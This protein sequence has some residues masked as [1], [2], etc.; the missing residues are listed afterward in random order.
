MERIFHLN[1]HFLTVSG[2]CVFTLHTLAVNKKLGIFILY[3]LPAFELV[4]CDLFTSNN[5]FL[6]RSFISSSGMD[7]DFFLIIIR[8]CSQVNDY[9]IS[10]NHNLK[11]RNELK[12]LITVTA[13][14]LNL[15]GIVEQRTFGVVR[16][17]CAEPDTILAGFAPV[18]ILFVGYPVRSS[19]ELPVFISHDNMAL[20]CGLTGNLERHVTKTLVCTVANFYTLNV[21]TL[22]LV[23]DG[24]FRTS[25]V[26]D[27]SILCD[28]KFTGNRTCCQISCRTLAFI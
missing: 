28:G 6:T 3:H 25:Q 16:F 27:F 9:F 11:S 2:E 18:G 4:L 14:F 12:T 22:D 8:E 13:Q 20:T 21:T 5:Y 1:F 17:R 15:V 26:N 10:G 7:G 19:G 23:V 24:L